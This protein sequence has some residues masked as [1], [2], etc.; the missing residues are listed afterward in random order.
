MTARH[1]IPDAALDDRL[2]FLGMTGSG[3]SYSASS[4]VER[5]LARRGRAIIPDPLGV[6]WGLRLLADGKTP[7]PY[8]IVI[9]GGPHADLPLT[10]HAGALIGETVAGMRESAIIDLSLFETAASERLFMLAFLD[11]LYRKTS[12][13]PVHLV[14]DEADLWCP[15]KFL[16]KEG[17]PQKLHG[18]MQ[19]VVRR[20]RVKGLTSWLISQRPAALSKSVLSQVDGLVAF[21]LTASQDRKALGLWIEGQADRE[22]GKAILNRLPE[23][24]QGE[25]VVWLP[26]RGILAD[27]TFPAKETYDSSRAPKRGEKRK[28][29]ELKPVDLG[30]LKERLA[31]V[32]AEV[33]ASD[34][35]VLKAEIARLNAELKKRPQNITQN[36]TA[37]DAKAIKAA[38][39]HGYDQGVRDSAAW[40]GP[41][42]ARVGD[43]VKALHDAKIGNLAD[44]VR[45]V[46][47][48]IDHEIAVLNKQWSKG[49][50]STAPLP[51]SLAKIIGSGSPA[52][53]HRQA[54]S[55]A[56]PM[57]PRPKPATRAAASGNGT[58]TGPQ[59]QLLASLAW[60]KAMGHE[61]ATR[62]QVASIAGWRVTSGHI[63]N[64]A[65]SLRTLGLIDYP[66]RGTMTL[67]REGEAL[68]PEPDMETTLIES[69][70]AILNGPQLIVFDNLP[71]DGSAMSRDEITKACGWE[72]GS[73]HIKNVLGSMRS[74]EVVEYP[75]RGEVARSEWVTE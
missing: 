40:H 26:A 46:T 72:V 25:A 5:I 47:K 39:E 38:T 41:P 45:S 30:A 28:A 71:A 67:T 65:G 70:R 9:F 7:S 54:P 4:C 61:R 64:V 20:G 74:L 73:G 49:H 60:W 8:E 2:G 19:S 44:G 24:K 75:S 12:G 32:E 56:A 6:W 50:P 21:R 42:L 69:V 63:K 27:V 16:D 62:V 68:A 3:K 53:V 59:R 57:A 13:E 43:A 29:V 52:P 36:I 17:A 15:E 48:L 31:T 51:K 1:P 35:K 23:K 58:I 18:I 22:A 66:D 10:P 11:A 55:A 37:P 14:F 33:R 34:P